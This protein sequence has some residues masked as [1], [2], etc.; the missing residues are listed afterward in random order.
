MNAQ[1]RRPAAGFTTVEIVV[2]IVLFSGATTGVL[3]MSQA[4]RDHRTAAVSASQQNA[5]AT[6]QSQVALQGINPALVGNPMQAA[7]EQAGTIG[8]SVSLGANTDLNIVRNRVAGF[9]VG[10]VSQPLGAQPLMGA[11]QAFLS[12]S[13]GRIFGKSRSL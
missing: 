4:V 2:A 7:I 8:T 1:S 12:S 6:F 9:E 10:A 11:L 3:L 13:I 5:Y